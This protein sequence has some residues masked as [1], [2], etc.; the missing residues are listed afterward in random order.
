PP[1]I[2]LQFEVTDTGIGIPP[3]KQQAIF[4]AFEQGD[5]ST[6]RRY[7]G[8]GLGLTIAARLT[9]MMGGRLGVQSTPARGSTFSFTVNVERGPAAP[10][11]PAPVTTP[12]PARRLRVL[13]AED[14]EVNQVLARRLLERRGH[15]VTVVDD[16][17]QALDA[18]AAGPFDM[19]L[20]DVQ[21]PE[22]D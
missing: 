1:P 4:Q 21:M 22:L 8:T 7:G 12:P 18:L 14:H 13:V 11:A 2:G 3:E 17:R 9:A 19:A 6:T 5:S 15:A 20:L 16:G 10:A